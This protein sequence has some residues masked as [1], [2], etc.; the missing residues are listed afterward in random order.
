MDARD[1]RR[2]PKERRRHAEVQSLHDARIAYI[3]F[4][5]KMFRP[6]DWFYLPSPDDF[7]SSTVVKLFDRTAQ[8]EVSTGEVTVAMTRALEAEVRRFRDCAI[9]SLP[10][11]YYDLVEDWSSSSLCTVINRGDLFIAE[12]R[13]MALLLGPLT[14]AI[15]VFQTPKGKTLVGRDMGHAWKRKV[16]ME[17]SPVGSRTAKAIVAVVNAE[18]TITA[19]EMDEKDDRVHCWNCYHTNGGSWDGVEVHTW[20]TGVSRSLTAHDSPLLRLC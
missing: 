9:K 6:S 2:T 13:H 19:E 18:L 11:E 10:E 17:F 1:A 14:L 7:P 15:S 3:D 5:E 12:R 8:P 20:R 16:Q 4:R